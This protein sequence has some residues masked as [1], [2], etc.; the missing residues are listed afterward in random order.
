MN[1][2][3]FLSRFFVMMTDCIGAIAAGGIVCGLIG[4]FMY[5]LYLNVMAWFLQARGWRK[6]QKLERKLAKYDA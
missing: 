5:V 1:T 3:V 4:S 2:F 6:T